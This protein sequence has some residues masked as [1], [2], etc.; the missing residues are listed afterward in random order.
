[1]NPTPASD[2][3]DW[4]VECIDEG[5]FFTWPVR[6]LMIATGVA[7]WVWATAWSVRDRLQRLRW[8]VAA[9]GQQP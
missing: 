8:R 3:P 2:C 6:L 4:L 7:L 5:L 9:R 1:M